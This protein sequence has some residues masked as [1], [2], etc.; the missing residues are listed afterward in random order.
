MSFQGRARSFV[1][2][3]TAIACSLV[4]ACGDAPESTEAGPATSTGNAKPRKDSLPP[5]MVAAVTSGD[6]AGSI[7]VHFELKAPPAIGMSLPVEVA[8]VPQ[9]KFTSVHATFL[10]PDGLQLSEGQQLAPRRDVAAGQVISHRLVVQPTSEGI[11]LISVGVESEGDEGNLTRIY[12]IPV[13]VNAASE[14]PP[15]G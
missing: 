4:A 13:I 15:A 5:G 1:F 7:S 2:V 14:A 6:R 3:C 11:F 10:A 9:R 8:I 12:S